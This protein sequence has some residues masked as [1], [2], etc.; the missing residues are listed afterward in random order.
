M[1]IGAWKQPMRRRDEAL[2]ASVI[3]SCKRHQAESDS[4]LRVGNES[5]ERPF[6]ISVRRSRLPLSAE[7]GG[8]MTRMDRMRTLLPKDE[9]AVRI[10]Y[11]SAHA[12][13]AKASSDAVL[14]PVR[15]F[16]SSARYHPR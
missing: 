8:S 16:R 6:L 14:A 7:S 11:G 1:G 13:M 4:P 2:P 9:G 10:E 15:A 3:A 5:I 12:A